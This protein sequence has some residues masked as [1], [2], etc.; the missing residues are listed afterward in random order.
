MSDSNRSDRV[1][2]IAVTRL[3]RDGEPDHTTYS[4]GGIRR[5]FNSDKGENVRNDHFAE[6]GERGRSVDRGPLPE[7]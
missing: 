5:S 1:D 4:Q 7:R 3:G 6:N 2:R